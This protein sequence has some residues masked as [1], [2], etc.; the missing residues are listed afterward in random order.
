M[1]SRVLTSPEKWK[2][3][4]SMWRVARSTDSAAGSPAAWDA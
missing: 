2:R 1:P 3:L 4:K